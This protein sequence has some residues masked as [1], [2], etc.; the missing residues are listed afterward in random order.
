MKNSTACGKKLT[1]L[2]K[3]LGKPE[4]P[5]LPESEDPIAVLVLSFLMWETSTRKAV[6]AYN[7]LTGQV[8]DSNDLR[9]CMP[10]EIEELIGVRYPMAH[11]RCQRMRAVLHDIYDREHAVTLEPLATMGKRDVKK[12]V[13]SLDGIV[14]YVSS[15]LMLLCYDTH[16]IPVDE[17]LRECLV[18]VKAA[19]PTADVLEIAGWL[20][21]QVRAGEGIECHHAFQAW[22]EEGGDGT[23]A[24]S[25]PK[26]TRKK[27]KAKTKT[28]SKK[29]TR[30]SSAGKATRS[31]RKTTKRLSKSR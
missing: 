26:T 5:K 23:A 15:R 2:L 22:A 1:S 6:T 27:S 31:S 19:D 29:T 3:K 20:T 16:A 4:P 18:A 17:Q 9:V 30:T 13:E 8:V 25:K 11:E 24:P 14:P 10:F 7:R 12:Y 21:R 28:K